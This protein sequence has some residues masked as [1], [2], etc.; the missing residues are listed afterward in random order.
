M[1]PSYKHPRTARRNDN[2][3]L[4]YKPVRAS[5]F[6]FSKSAE[7]VLFIDVGAKDVGEKR[8]Y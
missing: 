3:R 8:V 5:H 4:D 1:V 7:I 6:Q 2:R